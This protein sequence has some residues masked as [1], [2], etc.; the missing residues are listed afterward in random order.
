MS[1]QYLELEDRFIQHYLDKIRKLN[2]YGH[3]VLDEFHE[4]YAE[5]ASELLAICMI[6]DNQEETLKELK[7]TIQLFTDMIIRKH[8]R[9]LEG[10]P[11]SPAE[12]L[13]IKKVNNKVQK[14]KILNTLLEFE[15]S[16]NLV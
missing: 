13:G 14:N 5:L 16:M 6:S 9:D 4:P 15:K 12:K 11:L 3:A 10:R 1:K 2:T 7:M 8:Q